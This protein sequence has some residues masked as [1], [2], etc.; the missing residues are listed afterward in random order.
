MMCFNRQDT[1]NNFAV[2]L[3]SCPDMP[4]LDLVELLAE[5]YVIVNP[6]IK[7]IKSLVS[8]IKEA[9]NQVINLDF[10]PSDYY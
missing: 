2:E 8:E 1:I 10:D 4:F 3:E 9:V 5:A 6:D 7:D